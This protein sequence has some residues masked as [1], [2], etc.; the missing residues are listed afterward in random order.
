MME[1][2]GGASIQEI[3]IRNGRRQSAFRAYVGPHLHRSN[4]TV[5][6]RALVTRL[7]MDSRGVTGVEFRIG[8]ETRRVRAT[9]EVIVSSAQSTRRSCS[10]SQGSAMRPNCA[11]SGFR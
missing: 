6:T 8:N 2:D 5:L 4:L 7:T 9:S 3:R 10:C 11:S 1:S